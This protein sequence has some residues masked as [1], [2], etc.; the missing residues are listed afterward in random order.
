M[1]SKNELREIVMNE[2]AKME[3]S[4]EVVI[5]DEVPQKMIEDLE[6]YVDF[7]MYAKEDCIPLG[8]TLCAEADGVDQVSF[9][10]DALQT[11]QK[12]LGLSDQ[13]AKMNVFQFVRHEWRHMQQF[14]WLRKVGGSDLLMKVLNDEIN[15]A[16]GQGTLEADAIAFQGNRRYNKSFEEVFAAYLG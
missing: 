9:Q 11:W 10:L 5:N 1:L 3:W 2:V 4:F 16:Y 8:T 6:K 13:T 7:T 12:K 15:A 14:I